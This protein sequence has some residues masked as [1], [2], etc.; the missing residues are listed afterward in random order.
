M[1]DN[2]KNETIKALVWSLIERLGQQ[3]IQFIFSVIL[4]RLLLPSEFGLIA[5][6][7]VFISFGHSFVNAGFSHAL[8][9]KKITSYVDEC[10]IFYFNIAISLVATLVVYISAPLIANFYDQPELIPMTRAISLIFIFNAFGLIQKTILTKKL[11]F[12][13]L[14]NVGVLSTLLSSSMSLILALKGFGVWSL[15]VLHLSRDLLN[16]IFLWIFNSW[17]PRIL[18]SLHSLKSMFDFGSRLFVV[19]IT[20]SLFSNINQLVI[21]KFYNASSLGFYSRADSLYKYPIN[22]LNSVVSQVSFP[23]FSKIQDDKNRI[24]EA[25]MKT[26]SSVTLFSFPLMIGLIVIAK[27]LIEVLLTAKWLPSL[28]YLQMLCVVGMIKPLLV[29]NGNVIN[30]QGRSDIFMKIDILN[31]SLILIFLAATFRYGIIGIIIGQIISYTIAYLLQVYHLKKLIGLT[32]IIQIKKL[33][34]GLILSVIMGGILMVVN[35]II[36]ID[37]YLLI[38]IQ[39]VIGFL[40]YS[41]SCYILKIKAFMELFEIAKIKIV[42][43]YG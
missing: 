26:I 15:V 23:V 32:I 29:I 18:F 3:G 37:V 33:L 40:T 34:P 30:A 12:K 31:K 27:P 39:I 19:S 38:V 20:N 36:T 13:T 4:A 2:L 9:Q 14:F 24:K 28:P 16:T 6:L 11:D 21:G 17:R 7:Y 8:I 5:M 22:I 35:V 10:S 1:A 41:I 42:K 43:Y 25:T